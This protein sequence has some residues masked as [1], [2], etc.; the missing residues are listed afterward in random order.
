M[1]EDDWDRVLDHHEE[2]LE[3]YRAT[4]WARLLGYLLV[5]I[6][7]GA[8]ALVLCL[9]LAALGVGPPGWDAFLEYWWARLTP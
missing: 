6:T 3:A 1:R 5:G 9:A 2:E 7:G 8:T 4:W